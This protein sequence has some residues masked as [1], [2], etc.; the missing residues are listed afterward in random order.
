MKAIILAHHE[1]WDDACK[2]AQRLAGI[3]HTTVCVD[4]LPTLECTPWVA[5]CEATSE[6]MVR[7]PETCKSEVSLSDGQRWYRTTEK[8]FASFNTD[9]LPT[10][11]ETR[12]SP[13]SKGD[14]SDE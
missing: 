5:W 7:A 1:E 8:G 14:K 11:G 13:R 4:M 9:E 10:V 6:N 2:R 12:F 3:M